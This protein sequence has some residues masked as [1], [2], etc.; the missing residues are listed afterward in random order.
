MG[1][2]IILTTHHLDE[3]EAIADRIGILQNGQIIIMGSATEI[4]RS[5]GVGYILSV[6]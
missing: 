5:V 2:T 1:K 3:A 4:K 6:T